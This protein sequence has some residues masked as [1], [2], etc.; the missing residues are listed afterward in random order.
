MLLRSAFQA[1]EAALKRRMAM[2]HIHSHQGHLWN[3][4]ADI[5]AKHVGGHAVY[6]P[7]QAIDLQLWQHRIPYL[8][9]LFDRDAGLPELHQDGFAIRPP[10]LPQ[11]TTSEVTEERDKHNDEVTVRVSAATVNVRTLLEGGKKDGG[12]TSYLMEQFQDLNFNL[13]GLQET[14][15][16]EG[17]RKTG[18]GFL[19][20][21]SG[22]KQG[23][24][25]VELWIS[26]KQPIGYSWKDK[27]EVFLS[28]SDVTICYKDSRRLFAKLEK[29]GL[30]LS[31]LVLHAPH[32]GHDEDEGV[33]WW[34]ETSG[35]AR[36]FHTAG[37]IVV[38]GDCNA[39]S[40][41]VDGIHVFEKDD[42]SS[43]H[44]NAFRDFLTTC[45]LC[46]PTTG[47]WH[48][49]ESATWTIPNGEHESRID[50]TMV[51]CSFTGDIRHSQVLTELD[52]GDLVRDHR[53]LGLQLEWFVSGVP[54]S[55]DTQWRV[56]YDRTAILEKEIAQGIAADLSQTQVPDWSANIEEHVKQYTQQAH[57]VLQRWAPKRQGPAKKPFISDG[58][59]S[60]RSQKRD[61][62]R[63]LRHTH[64]LINREYLAVVFVAW[65]G[66]TTPTCCLVGWRVGAQFVVTLIEQLPPGASACDI[67]RGLRPAIGT[68]NLRKRK[69][70]SL[71]QIRDGNDQIC[72]TKE[73][74]VNAWADYFTAMEG[75]ERLAPEEQR[76]KWVDGLQCMMQEVVDMDITVCPNLVEVE[77]AFRRVKAGKA[78][79]LDGIPPELCHGC[80]KEAARLSYTQMMK[81]VCHGQEDL[82]HKGGSLAVAFK[83]GDRD[84]CSSYRS[85]L[86]SSHQGKTLHRALRQ[87]PQDPCLV[88]KPYCQ[89]LPEIPGAAGPLTWPSV[90][91]FGGGLLPCHSSFGSGW[92]LV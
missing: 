11:R 4:I 91:G 38:L 41:S 78:I 82:L 48:V 62:E 51:G 29:R 85:L 60:L 88:C 30:Y 71:P 31:V 14:R 20:Y 1:L 37:R 83:R 63:R 64:R 13:V 10:S 74:A 77:Q 3:E 92:S 39:K 21:C 61:A 58:I 89:G 65:A 76:T 8:W 90:F 73:D 43:K 67:L 53:A 16:Q 80:P 46:L 33:T 5:A 66:R 70:E 49:G 6:I 36:R 9:M 27:S 12:K 59:W 75:G 34:E 2:V 42:V 50:Y 86:I 69:G 19:R 45:D 15:T 25:G 17:F 23:N 44:T 18:K 84:G 87:R 22:C 40:G 57:D 72:S 35:I 68:S 56:N 52:L 26:Q 24:L 81:L 55:Q 32:S 54:T 28:A 47:A 79:G 7:R